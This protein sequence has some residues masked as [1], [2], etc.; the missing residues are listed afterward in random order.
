MRAA[1]LDR[2]SFAIATAAL[3]LWSMA[4]RQFGWEEQSLLTA[5]PWREVWVYGSALFLLVAC[6]GL[7]F[8]STAPRGAVAIG[9]YQAVGAAI[10]LPAIA[11]Q[12][13]SIG[14]WYP[15]FEA[16]TPLVAAWILYALLR[17]QSGTAQ[18]PFAT[19]GALR[20]AQVLFG[21]SC[22]FYGWSHFAYA[23]YTAGMV[24]RWLP[25]RLAFAYFTGAGHMAAGVAIIVGILPALAATLEAIMMALFGLLV[26]IPSF[27]AQTTPAWAKPPQHQWSELIITLVLAASAWIVAMSF[28]ARAASP[29]LSFKSVKKPSGAK[30]YLAGVLCLM[31]AHHAWGDSLRCGNELIEVGETMASVQAAC[32]SPAD[33]QH[34]V[35]VN[36][37][38]V[39]SG[40]NSRQATATEV[41]VET[42]TYNRG[43]NQLMM[44]IRFVDGKVVAIET[45]HQYGN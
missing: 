21:L 8:P 26:W 35:M 24:P 11:S 36:G 3:A 2:G 15:F 7:C 13:L 19:P 33:V 10:S 30:A 17:R 22:V 23:G 34:G 44:S 1:G 45:L 18:A 38:I 20:A 39:R 14:A 31:A 43:P 6:V 12:P 9:A 41:P 16:L 25:D 37:T 27:F 4:Y 42:W 28:E 5:I 32:G 29:R 40:D